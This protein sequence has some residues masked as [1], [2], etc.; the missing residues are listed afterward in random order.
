MR[1]SWINPLGP[2]SNDKCPY[3]KR[4]DRDRREKQ[5]GPEVGAETGPVGLLAWAQRLKAAP[6]GRREARSRCFSELQKELS[7]GHTDFRL[8]LPKTVKQ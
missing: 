8:L 4:R 2:E 5:E 3:R 7:C 6:A 1:S